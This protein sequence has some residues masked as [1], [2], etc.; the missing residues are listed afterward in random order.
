MTANLTKCAD[1]AAAHLRT[2][3]TPDRTTAN[4]VCAVGA[5]SV[6]MSI[7][8]HT[9]SAHLTAHESEAR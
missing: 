8:P 4:T 3:R 7:E 2:V 1:R 9:Y 5:H 6:R